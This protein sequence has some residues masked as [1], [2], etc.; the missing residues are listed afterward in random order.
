MI[1]LGLLD[2]YL[3]KMVS[4]DAVDQRKHI[5]HQKLIEPKVPHIKLSIKSSKKMI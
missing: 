2:D 5:L 1:K 4:C 3:D